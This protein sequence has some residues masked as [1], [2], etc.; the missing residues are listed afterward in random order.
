MASKSHRALALG[1][2]PWAHGKLGHLAAASSSLSPSPHV[3]FLA[4]GDLLDELVD[5][6]TWRAESHP[7]P[8]PAAFCPGNMDI[9]SHGTWQE[10]PSGRVRAD[11]GRHFLPCTPRNRDFGTTHLDFMQKATTSALLGSFLTISGGRLISG[12]LWLTMVVQG[13]P[14][15]PTSPSCSIQGG[16]SC[17]SL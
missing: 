1:Q 11:L 4:V 14:S 9:C 6:R 13:D 17:L 5:Q 3:L 16:H 8:L 15:R 2:K 10:R 7:R 12:Q